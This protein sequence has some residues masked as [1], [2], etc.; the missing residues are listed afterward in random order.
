MRY[1][2]ENNI[3]HPDQYGFR[4]N[5]GTETS[6]LRIYEQIAINQRYKYN[7]NI[8]CRDVSKSFDKIWHNGLCY[9]ILQLQLPD[10]IEKVL[11]NF[12]AERTAQI[13]YKN[14]VDDG[15]QISP[16][17]EGGPVSKPMSPNFDS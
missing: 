5:K 1:L 6:L 4:K 7:C 15:F 10:I 2:E 17:V 8:V 16:G 12:L 13:R 9:K 3:L 14:K 11:C